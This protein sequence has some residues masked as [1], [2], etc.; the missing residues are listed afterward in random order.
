MA[1]FVLRLF[2]ESSICTEESITGRLHE[3]Y[4]DSDLKYHECDMVYGL[5]K[6]RAG[7]L[8]VFSGN[9]VSLTQKGYGIAHMRKSKFGFVAF[10]KRKGGAL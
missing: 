4:G 5:M 9:L 3:K 6:G 10:W 8:Y 7:L 1:E 2:D